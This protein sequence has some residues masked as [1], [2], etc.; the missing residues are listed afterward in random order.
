MAVDTSLDELALQSRQQLLGM[1]DAFGL[2][3]NHSFEVKNLQQD[4]L[5]QTHVRFQ[6]YY[7][8]IRIWGG[9]VVT[10]TQAGGI[11]LPPTAVLRR[12][13]LIDIEPKLSA[14]EALAVVEQDNAPRVRFTLKP[15]PELVVYPNTFRHLAAGNALTSGSEPN[16]A[17]FVTDVTGY[18]LAYYVHTERNNPGDTQH[19]DYLIDADSGEVIEKWDSLMTANAIG[20]G[21]SQYSGTVPL[22]S[23][24][25]TSGF[26]LK[27]YTRPGSGANVV[28]NLDHA[29]SG[30]GTLY[31]DAD[32]TWG[33]G[34]NY[35]EDPEPT[36]SANGQTAAV[37]AAY[38]IQLTWDMYKNV[39]GRNGIDGQG[40]A[41]YARVHYDYAYD[42]AFYSTYCKCI[43]Y[44]DGT[45]LQTLTALDVAAHEFSHGVCT[46]TADLIYKQESGGLNEANSDIMGTMAEFYS[47]G[48]NGKGN[49]IPGTGGNWTH[50]EQMTTPAYPLKMRF[51]YKPSND[52]KSADAWSPSLKDID[53]H[54]SSGPMNRAFYFLSQGATTGGE[55]SSSYLPQGMAGIGNDKAAKIWFRAM[56]VYM[57]PTT[58]YLGARIACIKATRD[59]YGIS[60][61]E[62]IAVWNAFAAINV[63]D[64][65]SGPDAAPVVNVS[66]IGNK[67]VLT[68]SATASDDKGVVKM[69]FFLDGALVG[70]MSAPP[71][72]ISYDSRMQD[73]GPHTL[74][75]RATDTTGQYTDATKTITI[76]NGQLIRN[77]S[78]EKGYGV[79]WSNT[80]GMQIGAILNETPYD[81]SK[82]A[83]FCGSGSEKSVAL[84]QTVAIPT[85][86]PSA[87]LS[88]ALHIASDETTTS[89]ARDTFDVQLR[90]GSGGILT[91]LATYSNLNAK[92]GYQLHSHDVS[93]YKGQSVQ[94]Y[95]ACAEDS[96]L[97]T[98]FIL[99]K[100]NL[101]VSAGGDGGDPVAPTVS[102]VASGSS[103]IITLSAAAADNVGVVKVEFYVDN[104]LKGTD[105]AAPYTL[106]LNSSTLSNGQHT[107]RAKAY[108]AA[109]NVGTSAQVSFTVDNG[110]EDN[111]APAVSVAASGSS[112]SI[113]F[114]ATASDN[115]GVSKV[116]F[117]ADNSLKGS[118]TTAPYSLVFDSSTLSNGS[119]TLLGKAYDAAG[120]VGISSP[121]SFNVD[122]A[123]P[124]A[125]VFNE[126]ESNG[127]TRTANVI[128][129]SVTK[130]VAYIDSSVDKDYF[131]IDLRPG[132]SL[133]ADMKGPP[134]DYELYLLSGNGRLLRT[135]A[136]VGSN[137]SVSY[138]NS[139][140]SSASYFLKVA[141]FGGAYSKTEP[142]TITLNR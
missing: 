45:K 88:Y 2:D 124:G 100:V 40:T 80:T 137:E 128:G 131:K 125:Q 84:F 94:V 48:A 53:V 135:S 69:E 103:G 21:K 112:G 120:N 95:F 132:Q 98:G 121:V 22:N 126:V 108:D 33:D 23:S 89:S 32:N 96:A 109:G 142:Y 4:S 66:V 106:A 110:A 91:T 57:T 72:T 136:N 119:H 81:G 75:A 104:Q 30:T 56:T 28:F 114:S 43:T 10:H 71:Y 63:G 16:A 82:M 14:A 138:T 24:S 65:W 9:E 123:G 29:T 46:T 39:F 97:A 117:Y 115:V 74:V 60:G 8:G 93:A 6:Q 77:G 18:R 51:M 26:E 118:D 87:T 17:D 20:T 78:F 101:I 59:L 13:I 52:G 134:R 79:G 113:T 58:D 54:Y 61:A 34:N 12:E 99:D 64:P 130:I 47:R 35:K 139:G 5:G 73:D 111:E 3:E 141:A 90:N 36:T 11:A 86:T 140:S 7:H 105:Q 102:A 83:K 31:T 44:G 1:R 92:T 15:E 62:E 19:I 41:T 38:G 129:S 76:A 85:A 37:D 107:L 68:F 42:N 116:E 49:V 70:G 67:G 55:T 127:T 133:T 25:V 122:N 50:G 27:D